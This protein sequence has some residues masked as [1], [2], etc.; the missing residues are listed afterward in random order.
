MPFIDADHFAA[1]LRHD[2]VTAMLLLLR[3]YFADRCHMDGAAARAIF[4]TYA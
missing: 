4:A 2:A 1:L 3:H